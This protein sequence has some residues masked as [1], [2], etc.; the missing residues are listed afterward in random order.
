[1]NMHLI[2]WTIVVVSVV[3]LT[4]FSLRTVRYMQGVT[5]FLSANRSAGRYML[6]LA[7]GMTG[8][9]AISAVGM[10]EQY[11]DAGFPPIWWGWMM[12]PASVVVTL[13][14]WVFYRFRETRC[15]TLAQF[16]ELRY[17]RRF[18]IYT[19]LIVWFS[20][21][22]NFGIFHYVAS[23]FFVY[24]CGL[25]PELDVL[26]VAI[27]TYWPVMG[28][29][30]GMALVY[31]CI[32]GHITVMIT[33]CVQGIFCGMAFVVLCIVLLFS[34]DWPVL[35]QALEEAPYRAAVVQAKQRV[36]KAQARY[37]A[38]LEGKVEDTKERKEELDAAVAAQDDEEGLR[39]AAKGKSMLNPFDTAKVKNFN[40]WF[41][42]IIVFNMFYGT[43]AWQGSQA[44]HSSGITPHE[45]KMGA[46]IGGW[47]ILL[48]TATVL[49]LALCALTF[50]QHPQYAEQAS[51]ANR[52]LETLRAGDTPQL[53][54]QQRVPIALAYMLPVGFRGL[55]CVVMM[56]LLVTTQDTYVHSW[57]TI[58]IQDVVMPWR[59]EPF[60][61]E[62]HVRAL[63]WSIAFVAVF[64]VVFSCVYK[65]TE[66]IQM[67][68]AITGA[69][70]GGLGCV[71]VGGLYWRRAT[72]PA[73]YTAVTLGA[74]L[75]VTRIIVHQLKDTIAEKADTSALMR[76]LD[77]TNAINSQVVWFF[78]MIFCIFVFATISLLTCRRPFNMER[79]LHR[80]KYDTK[81]DHKKAEDATKSVWLKLVGITEEFSRTDRILA[82]GL[83][84]WNLFWIGLFGGAALY[85]FVIAQIPADWWP[86]FWRLWVFLQVGVG[87]PITIWFTI[88][89]AMD[90]RRVFQRLATVQR[91]AADDGWVIHHH[92]PGDPEEAGDTLDD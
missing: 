9:G 58:F 41:Y 32:G 67:Y 92:L 89:G 39:E 8:F 86:K 35:T 68:F 25:P 73:A 80:G 20:G 11:A 17:N 10:F 69:I 55:F 78:V 50:L 22:V 72:T 34:F 37:D 53:A 45:Q 21:I 5:D 87:I 66:F 88:G 1:M 52:M 64:A 23:N 7:G 85:N 30:T 26:G 74:V 65:P 6:T 81:G 13:S 57:G 44:Y 4:W 63:R 12:I 19:G 54:T 28:L 90:I 79:M 40:I 18:R 15:L 76:L 49:L 70:V 24:F 31:T 14:G 27:P 61:P 42:L 36:V 46:I 75:S 33:D 43:M 29:T 77:A 84:L 59:K 48:Q 71:I 16:F 38:A 82:G 2:D 91:D 47:R 56:F 60:T 3:A 83:V 62:G 51:G